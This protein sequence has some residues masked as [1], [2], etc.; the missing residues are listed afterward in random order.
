VGR[1]ER[2]V[3]RTT[4]WSYRHSRL[5]DIYRRESRLRAWLRECNVLTSTIYRRNDDDSF[6][7]LFTDDVIVLRPLLGAVNVAAGLGAGAVGL[8]LLPLDRGHLL[9]VR[10][11]AALV[12]S[13][14]S[15][16]HDLASRVQP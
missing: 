1:H 6:F 9:V 13:S 15:G 11:R 4:Q 12:S 5:D 10:L 14:R 3:E 7:L 8:V 16:A 2:V